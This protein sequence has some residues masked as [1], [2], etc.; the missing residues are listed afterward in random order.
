MAAAF[1]QHLGTSETTASA[2]T[3]TVLSISKTVTSGNMIVVGHV[4]YGTTGASPS[5][6]DNLG[7]TYTLR[8]HIGN[9]ATSNTSILTAPVTSAGTLTTITVTH[10]SRQYRAILASEYSGVEAFYSTGG[11]SFATGTTSTWA[12]N[13]VI[14]ANGIAFGMVGSNNNSAQSAGAASGSPS[15]TVVLDTHYASPGSASDSIGAFYAIAGASDVTAFSGT[16]THASI[17]WSS[18]GAVFGVRVGPYVI[19][20]TE[21]ERTATTDPWTFSATIDAATKGCVLLIGHGTS[22]T[23]H[24]PSSATVTVGGV[25]MA[26]VASATDTATEPGRVDAWFLGSGIPSAGSQ[27]V[28]V[29]LAS[30]TTDDMHFVLVQLGGS[31]DMEVVDSDAVSENTANPSVTLN[32]GGRRCVAVGMLY[33][34]VANVITDATP[35]ANMSTAQTFDI[36][37]FGTRADYQTTAGTSDFTFSYTAATDD[38]AMVAIAV[39]EVVAAYDGTWPGFRSLSALQAVN[40]A[41]SF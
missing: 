36:A 33:S 12:A 10:D 41:G 38:V 7:N 24:V 30:A 1:V 22:A 26:Y 19:T 23:D 4:Y 13:K 8:E 6:T 39:A 29:D 5:A 18:V 28:S 35:N 34:G 40:R 20:S 11:G 16:A 17:A 32:Y 25:A 14:P 15:T 27:T 2:Q 37:A 3:T 31:A 9:N 21:S